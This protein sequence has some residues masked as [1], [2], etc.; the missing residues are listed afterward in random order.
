MLIVYAPSFKLKQLFIQ[1]I[2]TDIFMFG[3]NSG[4]VLK[5]MI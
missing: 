3:L 2:F 4:I 1:S 5:L